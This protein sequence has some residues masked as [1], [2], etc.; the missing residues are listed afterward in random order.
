MNEYNIL[1]EKEME[2]LISIDE[3]RKLRETVNIL[4]MAPF[5]KKKEFVKLMVIFNQI[6]NRME[7]EGQIQKE[8]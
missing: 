8:E 5:L 2:E 3:C 1:D 4:T 6:V 7:N